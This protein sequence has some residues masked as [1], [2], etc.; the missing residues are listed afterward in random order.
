M[1]KSVV[2]TGNLVPN[3][4]LK[5]M[6]KEKL[7]AQFKKVFP[8]YI[9]L[10]PGFLA[11]LIF[12]YG[13]MY[14]AQIAFRNYK[15][16]RGIYGSDW[17]GFDNFIEFFTS[18]NFTRIVT[19]TLTISIYTLIA[20][21]ICVLILSLLI[22]AVISDK[23]KK[24]VQTVTY[25]PH[26]ISTVVMVGIVI[27]MF[28][29]NL[30][31]ISQLIQMF[32]GTNRDLM[33]IPEAFPHIYVWS[34]VWQSA[35][36]GTIIYLATLSGTSSE[37]HEAAMIDGATRFQRVIH[38]DVPTVIPTAVI[39]LILNLGKVINVGSEKVLLMQNDLNISKSEII[40]TYVYKIGLNSPIPDYSLSAAVGLFNSVVSLIL[41]IIVN[42][43][44]NKLTQSS[45]W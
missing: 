44:A 6:K 4:V 25:L 8:L 20:N 13:P 3:D 2:E 26:F 17:V 15:P 43:I 28:N 16:T 14:G 31:V 41:V 12:N 11:V 24:T 30:G 37:L 45:L 18:R 36:W 32:G 40:S 42:K 35:G 33:G 10:I 5:K 23:F 38:I 22:N 39:M 9:M 1:K 7:K 19:N 21:T 27:K 29:P 34:E